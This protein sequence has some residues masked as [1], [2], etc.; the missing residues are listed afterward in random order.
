MTLKLEEKQRDE[1]V[2]FLG[3]FQYNQVIGAIQLLMS[4]P[5]IEE[6]NEDA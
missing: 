5:P 4:L 6:K 2:K 1:L 3:N